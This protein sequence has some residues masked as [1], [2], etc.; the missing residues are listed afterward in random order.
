MS[1][2]LLDEG[3]GRANFWLMVVGFN[4]TF[5]VQ[6]FLGVMGMPRR[7]FTYPDLPGW[8][9]LNMAS[10]VGAFIMGLSVLVLAGNIGVSLRR[11]KVA[12]DNPWEAWT[13]EWAT[14]SPP[15]PH[16]FDHLPLVR[17]RRPLLDPT[18]GGEERRDTTGM[19]RT[20]PD[21]SMVA[22]SAFIV[23]ETGFFIILILS[24]VYFNLS[25][26]AAAAALDVKTTGIF[27]ACLIASSFTFYIAE[28][29]LARGE[30]AAFRGWLLFTLLL[31]CVFMGGQVREYLKLFNRGVTV[32]SSLFAS[33]FFTLTGFHGLH[34]TLG[35]VA[36]GILA[37]LAF[38]GDFR[39]KGSLGGD[40][41]E[42]PRRALK[43][44]GLY[45][46]FVD[47]VWI[48]VFSIVYVRN[49]L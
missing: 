21:K 4:L 8:G 12:G 18:E 5:F 11:G 47:V 44:V 45:W 39:R 48:V 34:V 42:K 10:T 1:G 27:T 17:S 15:V 6:H 28:R 2:R 43:A 9:A 46:H 40:L 16:N 37:G 41:Q 23:S 7:V 25:T 14:T 32:D 26:E 29:N 38:A 22:V 24:Y 36:L 49:V 13:L 31:G 20:P 19:E 35:L 3:L 33:T 30:T